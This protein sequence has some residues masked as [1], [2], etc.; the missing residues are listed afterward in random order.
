[1]VYRIQDGKT[2]EALE[3]YCLDKSGKVKK[4]SSFSSNEQS[5]VQVDADRVAKII[6][7]V[8][9]YG[10]IIAHNHLSG[11]SLPSENDDRFTMEVQLMC[12]INGVSLYDHCIYASDSNVFSYF[13]SGKIDAI[14]R[15]FSFDKLVGE[16]YKKDK[17]Q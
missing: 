7:A 8:K 17:R 16:Q 3:L 13:S 14:K 2:A 11:S 5:K 15:S 12:S 1:M 6:S 9:P 10:L 4:I